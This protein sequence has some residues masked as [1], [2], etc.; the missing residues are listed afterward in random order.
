MQALA[1]WL[2]WH[3]SS[4]LS[5]APKAVVLAGSTRMIVEPGMTGAT[6]NIYYGLAEWQEMAFLLHVLRPDDTFV[7][8][9]A[10]IGV[11]ALLASGV[12]GAHSL[13]AEPFRSTFVRLERNIA[14]NGLQERIRAKRMGLSLRT[15]ELRFTTSQDT[16]NHIV[17]ESEPVNDAIETCPVETLDRWLEAE[18][19]VL[20]KIDVE[21]HDREVLNGSRSILAKP[22]LKALIV[23]TW[24]GDDRIIDGL[25]SAAQ[26]LESFGFKPY[27]NEPRQ[28]RV[29]PL[30][31]QQ[32]GNVIYI[33]DLAFINERLA[34][35]VPIELSRGRM[36]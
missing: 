16:M 4:R 25:P 28:K 26:V 13:A 15:G 2:W 34:K 9:G 18:A 10:N 30:V 21:G 29:T 35:S 8:V 17:A 6:G 22:S 19:P 14:V 20:I 27:S 36:I 33:R 32:G 24:A 11:F 12:A 5:S 7:D 31:D 23:E 3:I 1:S